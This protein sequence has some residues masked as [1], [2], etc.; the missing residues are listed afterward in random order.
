MLLYSVSVTRDDLTGRISCVVF[1]PKAF[2]EAEAM[3]FEGFLAGSNC[4]ATWEH[5]PAKGASPGV[6]HGNLTTVFLGASPCRFCLRGEFW[7]CIG[8]PLTRKGVAE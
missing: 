5:L 3:A 6:G 1:H 7:A 8:D 4:V 2:A